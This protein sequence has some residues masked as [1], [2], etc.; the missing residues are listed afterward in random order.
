MSLCLG[1]QLVFMS[2]RCWRSL[3][4]SCLFSGD[5]STRRIRMFENAETT[6]CCPCEGKGNI[7]ERHCKLETAGPCKGNRTCAGE[8]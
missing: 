4:H 5:E 1:A 6:K 2:N 7:W 3:V 8:E